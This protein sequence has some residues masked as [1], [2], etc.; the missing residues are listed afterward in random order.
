M[1]DSIFPKT[2]NDALL[3]RGSA[4]TAADA[5]KKAEED[6]MNPGPAPDLADKLLSRAGADSLMRT[7]SKLGRRS[8]F[9][10]G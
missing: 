2:V 5:K 4:H 7:K 1:A 10:S 3:Q 9:L 6:A 8:T